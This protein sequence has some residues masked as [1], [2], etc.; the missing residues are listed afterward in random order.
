MADSL[1]RILADAKT[2]KFSSINAL[3]DDDVA[4][5]WENVG[6]YIEKK[7]ASQKG[8]QIPNL[9]TFSFSQNKLD[10]GNNK[11]VLM[12][13]P[14]FNISEKFA[15][16]HGLQFTRYNV[17]GHIPCPP[18]NYA[19][20]SFESPFSRDT[21][22]NC[23]REIVSSVNRAVA[24]KRNVELCFA[25]I[26]RLQI[27][28][29]R[30]KM[31]FYK[32]F[33]NQMDGSGSLLDSMQN[34]AGTVDSVMSNRPFS[35]PNTSNTVLLPRIQPNPGA[36][37]TLPPLA[38]V[39]ENSSSLAEDARPGESNPPAN[40]DSPNVLSPPDS[41]AQPQVMG[42]GLG[43]AVLEDQAMNGEGVTEVAVDNM[44]MM[45]SNLNPDP[46]AMLGGGGGDDVLVPK[47]TGEE[48]Q[49]EKRALGASRG[50]SRMAMPMATACGVSLLDDLVPPKPTLQ[51]HA[52]APPPEPRA[53]TQ[54]EIP[55]GSATKAA[56]KPPTP[57]RL[58]PLKRSHSSDDMAVGQRSLM[59][60]K[61]TGGAPVLGGGGGAACGGHHPASQ[62]L[63]R[64]CHLRRQR[65][66]PV[67]FTE[68]RRRREEEEDRILQQYHSLK[69]AEDVLKEQERTISKRH[70][71]QKI[72]A[73]NLGVSEVVNARKKAKDTQPQK[74]Y[75]FDRRPLTPPRFPKQEE[76][77][78]ELTN[79]VEVR[80]EVR[81]KEKAD[82]EFLDRLEQVQLAE[83]LAKQRQQFIKDKE[84]QVNMYKKAL[85]VQTQLKPLPI[86]GRQP[87]NEVFGKNDTTNEVLMER[88]RRAHLLYQEQ[89][90]LVGQQKREAILK[91]LS[92][93]K[94]DEL[95]LKKT[96][97]DLIEDRAHRHKTRVD[98]R[99]RLEEDWKEA[100]EAKRGRDAEERQRALE[101]G[102]L[103]Q[104]QCDH[105]RRCL[106]CRR[107][108]DNCGES[109]LWSESYYIPG[110][111]IMV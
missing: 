78:G 11:Y 48:I 19:A 94:R 60:T 59:E 88:R 104:E 52:P 55:L 86:P 72:S 109:N 46:A 84:E 32:E 96:R 37:N 43:T 49:A 39:D 14:V 66:V 2:G 27:R 81:S 110:S 98:H 103:L 85:D 25:G 67:S 91:R 93:Q 76:Y 45:E 35:R 9:G 12:Q 101:C 24:S 18:L 108:V 105:Y 61:R 100:A 5:V 83:D 13:R 87:D 6:S 90:E 38:E 4:N 23:V 1:Q 16:T 57:P 58:A 40:P 41:E 69:D 51:Q 75:I 82:K 21:V 68:E 3:S 74:S 53:V 106:Q 29:S 8:V 31:R 92:Q 80:K 44:M 42:E 71:L 34:R 47:V 56:L 89:Q 50:P 33:I 64:L 54:A 111:R 26:G 99:R 36:S 79:Q 20:L 10:V 95:V 65:N 107:R 73:F 63:C 62:E 30:V 22:E 17:P 28:D 77:L 15:Q 7:M 102:H 70:D 97:E